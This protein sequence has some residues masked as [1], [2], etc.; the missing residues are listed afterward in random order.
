MAWGAL[1]GIASNYLQGSSSNQGGLKDSNVVRGLRFDKGKDWWKDSLTGFGLFGN[2]QDED[3]ELE[4]LRTP[5]Q[6]A[7]D[8]ALNQLAMTGSWNGL[9]LGEAYNGSLGNYDTSGLET[10]YGQLSSLYN[11]QDIQKARDTYTK[12]SDTT[13]N[14]D[15]PSSGYA[16]FSRQLARAGK[17]SSSALER[18]SAISG[19]RFGTA[20]LGKKADLASEMQDQRGSFL[21][22]LYNQQQNRALQAAGGLQNLAGTQ[23]NLSQSAALQSEAIN[24]IKDQQAKNMLSEYMRQRTEKLGQIDLLRDESAKNAYLGITSLPAATDSTSSSIMS[25]LGTL[26]SQYVSSKFANSGTNATPA[27]SKINYTPQQTAMS[28]T[29]Y[30]LS[31]YTK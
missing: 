24:Q 20:I 5:E 4:D 21:A 2:K 8:A 18:E 15:D 19:N 1:A 30:W 14:P 16:A 13:F 9:T 29:G 22:N 11:G 28:N 25:L 12:L 7:A 6:K 23:A 26:G 17:E 10:A 3:E 27:V 31:N